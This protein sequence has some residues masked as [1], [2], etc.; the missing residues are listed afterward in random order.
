[1]D[2]QKCT[3]TSL[4]FLMVFFWLDMQA[5]PFEPFTQQIDQGTLNFDFVPV[6]GGQFM[7]GS[8]GDS[9]DTEPN[10]SPVHEVSVDDFWMG[11]YEVDWEQFDAFV[12]QE[13]DS[14]SSINETDLSALGIDAISGAYM[15]YVDM[16]FN[17]G[18]EGYP[19]VNMTQHGAIMFCQ[20]LSAKTGVFYRLPTEAEWEYACKKGA[21]SPEIPLTEQA[22]FK[23]NADL[24]YE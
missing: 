1:M 11:V 15:P 22:W 5:Q 7:M 23:K 14:I 3:T 20:W 4:F 6:E 24:A 9:N 19:A 10:E 17:M 12:F 8:N 18:K 16:S 13:L 21:L 2:F